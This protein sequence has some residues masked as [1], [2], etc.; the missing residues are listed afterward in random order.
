[1]PDPADSAKLNRFIDYNRSAHLN[2]CDFMGK[3]DSQTFEGL[4]AQR[5]KLMSPQKFPSFSSDF[6]TLSLNC[7]DADTIS[8]ESVNHNTDRILN[9]AVPVELTDEQ[10]SS[11]S[12]N[13]MQI[14]HPQTRG[15]DL[16]F[17]DLDTSEAGAELSS[18]NMVAGEDISD[19]YSGKIMATVGL[20]PEELPQ[21]GLSYDDMFE[22]RDSSHGSDL[23]K[24]PGEEINSLSY[25]NV[26]S[27]LNQH[28]AT[29]TMLGKVNDYDNVE[30]TSDAF[31]G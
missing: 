5:M 10:A 3:F 8:S 9:G 20:E 1:M 14:N 15:I 31:R 26:I 28:S 30:S 22:D 13:F 6:K 12:R 11:S 24:R 17:G 18:T 21:Q 27:S 29:E 25:V 16:V 23:G 19:D 7:R 4:V 2:K